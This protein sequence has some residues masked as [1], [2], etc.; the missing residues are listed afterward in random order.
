MYQTDYRKAGMH[1]LP[2]DDPSGVKTGLQM[3][4]HAM[5]LLPLSMVPLYFGMAGPLYL[6]S[7]LGLG[8]IFLGSCMLFLIRRNDAAARVVF[9][10]SVCYLP[11]LFSV[12]M[13]DSRG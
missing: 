9:L 8:L 6:F 3:A 4:V 13:F 5:T 11:L 10:T 12:M 2:N 7:A 1:M